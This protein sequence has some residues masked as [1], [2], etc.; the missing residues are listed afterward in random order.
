[1]PESRRAVSL[2]FDPLPSSEDT[3]ASRSDQNEWVSLPSASTGAEVVSFMS[4]RSIT[5][6]L[7]LAAAIACV[8]YI[9][10]HVLRMGLLI[11]NHLPAPVFGGL[12]VM[13]LM[14]NPLLRRLGIR[15]LIQGREWAVAV[16]V[17]MAACWAPG[18]GLLR[19]W[20]TV[21]AMPAHIAQTRLSW[22]SVNITSYMPGGSPNFAEGMIRDWAVFKDRLGE[23]LTDDA[24]S[25]RR[26]PRLVGALSGT[27]QRML[28]Q[29]APLSAAQRR[30]LIDDLNHIMASDEFPL[31]TGTGSGEAE[32]H[33]ADY[34]GPLWA[35]HRAMVQA[36]GPE[37]IWHP[38]GAG[39]MITGPD[40]YQRVVRPWLH[41]SQ[42]G[43]RVGLGEIPWDAWWPPVRLWGV[44]AAG[45]GGLLICLGLIVHDQWSRRELL[46]Y[47]LA[48]FTGDLMNADSQFGRSGLLGNRL[49]Q[50]GL[51][52]VLAIHGINGL[53]A[54]QPSLPS[55]PLQLDFRPLQQLFPYARRVPMNDGLFHPFIYFSVIA[56]A[57]Y[58]HAKVSFSLGLSLVVFVVF[59]TF[60]LRNGLPTP[61]S[62]RDPGVRT[63]LIFGCWSAAA[64]MLLVLGR[65]YYF[66]L[67]RRTLGLGGSQHL[68]NAAAIAARC[69]TILAIMLIIWLRVYA[70]ID[71]WLAA[72]F[73]AITVM[74]HL[75][76]ARIAAETGVFFLLC[77]W[78]PL[79]VMI[80]LLGET[81]F[82]PSL[83]IAL[84]LAGSVMNA[85]ARASLMPFVVNGL[86]IAELPMGRK[87][88]RV[89]PW[90]VVSLL[91]SLLLAGAATIWVQYN[92]GPDFEDPWTT[93]GQA[94]IPLSEATRAV[95]RLS[96]TDQ[97]SAVTTANTWQRLSMIEPTWSTIGFALLGFGLYAATAVGRLRISWFPLH[98][99]LFLYWG[100]YS[101]HRFGFSLLIGW[102]I[103]VLTVRLGGER[104]H[105]KLR[106]LM[107]GLIA[108][109]LLAIVGWSV[110]GLSYYLLT[111][112]RPAVYPILPL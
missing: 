60:L 13:V 5:V 65:H 26:L 74:A 25:S 101:S 42:P 38:S 108:G 4:I 96:A 78:S 12:V 23:H 30:A 32:V 21:V 35:R 79:V 43:Q 98:P 10:N 72:L 107:V 40:A 41:G 66:G 7:L 36:I 64:V 109:E 55:I 16:T 81:L 48:Q 50:M 84:F 73:L 69:G 58:L 99:V 85:G 86:K 11:N 100:T 83:L 28:G 82:G 61:Y 19:H 53:H 71:W 3:T 47:P 39:W 8:T 33:G 91:L 70:G 95:H 68:P 46:P 52:S 31:K 62:Q 93:R 110:V 105:E 56:F 34:A 59:Q 97:L 9:N 80:G 76:L 15:P 17:A 92:T 14:V 75:I 88:G 106:P 102:M 77:A 49:F 67:A 63:M 37:L 89:G 18:V 1:M 104:T 87:V 27:S 6:G 94:S 90:L 22:Q 20:T 45:F 2:P 44:V 112:L 57:F 111:G 29:A 51:V 103:K 54:W 24:D